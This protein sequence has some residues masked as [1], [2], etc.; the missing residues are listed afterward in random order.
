MPESFAPNFP[1]AVVTNSEIPNVVSGLAQWKSAVVVSS[2]VANFDMRCEHLEASV[3]KTFNRHNI[4]LTLLLSSA[5]YSPELS[6]WL[7]RIKV[8][9]R[10]TYY[11]ESN[12]NQSFRSRGFCILQIDE[13]RSHTAGICSLMSF[14][15]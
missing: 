1:Y 12:V 8:A 3:R 5:T 14:D 7:E 11:A 6:Q 10:S 4:A 13:Q 9:G 15:I 2:Q